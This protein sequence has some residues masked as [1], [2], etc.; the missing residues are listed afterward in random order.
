MAARRGHLAI[1]SIPGSSLQHLHHMPELF[2][3]REGRGLLFA[4]A[5][6]LLMHVLILSFFLN[7]RIGAD[8]VSL[9]H[10]VSIRL[11]PSNP[12]LTP[13]ET[14]VAEDLRAQAEPQA[15]AEVGES[16]PIAEPRPEQ[17]VDTPLPLPLPVQPRVNIPQIVLPSSE[18]L[19]QS[20]RAVEARRT[21][22]LWTYDCTPQQQESELITCDDRAEIS[23]GSSVSR[24][25]SQN[26]I[27]SQTYQRFNPTR[28]VTRAQRS[29]PVVSS[30]APSLAARLDSI[31]IPEDLS[32][33]LLQEVEAGI[34]H[35]ANQGSLAADMH[36]RL[37]DQS[38]AAQ[39]ARQ[40][41][42]DPWI[43]NRIK[44]RLSTRIPSGN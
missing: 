16:P 25:S 7:A 28:E 39:Q 40:F 9:P 42:D 23:A 14:P 3:S 13:E 41:T 26:A 15:P 32:A 38:D 19:V 10:N 31:A 44:P 29:L 4:V 17:I 30:N 5:A 22:R 36:D 21:S 11:V 33:Y 27:T 20:I 1:Q 35:N 37:T 2:S 12:L 6:S 24:F 8:P 43:R 18:D 34:S